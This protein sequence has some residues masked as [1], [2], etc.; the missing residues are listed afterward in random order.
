MRLGL[1]AQGNPL[2]VSR[3]NHKLRV[4]GGCTGPSTVNG[5][6]PVVSRSNHRLSVSGVTPGQ[7]LSIGP[8]RRGAAFLG[9]AT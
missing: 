3:S 5:N 6:P 7:V 4:S 8:E 1:A 9:R 2:M